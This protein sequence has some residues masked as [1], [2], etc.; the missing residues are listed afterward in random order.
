M[1][2]KLN[3]L[4]VSSI[5]G[6]LGPRDEKYAVIKAV[7]DYLKMINKPCVNGVTLVDNVNTFMF[8]DSDP[9]ITTQALSLGIIYINLI[10]KDVFVCVSKEDT[11]CDWVKFIS[12]ISIATSDTPGLV[13]ADK[14]TAQDTVPVHIAEDNKLYVEKQSTSAS[15]YIHNQYVS[16]SLWVI[17]HNLHKYPSVYV[18][19]SGGSAVVGSIEYISADM[20]HL[21]FSASFSG[22]A[23]LN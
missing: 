1:Q 19:D 20:I 21:Q 5:Q 7:T 4:S 3:K 13:Q 8:G 14:V 18:V 9:D 12:N 6:N 17:Q 2:G 16:S 15:T 23:Y 10:T 11:H 22:T